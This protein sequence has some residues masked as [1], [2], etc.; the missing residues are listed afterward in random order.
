MEESDGG[1]GS[2]HAEGGMMRVEAIAVVGYELKPGDL[3]S[4]VGPEYWSNF[5]LTRS[6]GERCYIRTNMPSDLFPD[7]GEIVYKLT[8]HRDPEV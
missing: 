8:I 3:F 4:T 6:V 5:D 2:E 1:P 7:A